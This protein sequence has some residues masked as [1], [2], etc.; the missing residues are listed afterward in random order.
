MPMYKQWVLSKDAPILNSKPKTSQKLCE[1]DFEL[2]EEQLR[3]LCKGEI[4]CRALFL[5]ID[6]ITRLYISYG[7]GPGGPMPGR[8]VARIVESKNKNFPKGKLVVGSMGWQTYSIVHPETVQEMAGQT[9]RLVEPLPN[10]L[11]KTMTSGN[12]LPKSASLGVLGIPGLTAHLALIKVANAQPGETL[13]ISSAAGQIGHLAGQIGKALGLHVIGY[14]GDADKASWIKIELGLDW[15]F[16]YKTQDVHQTLKIAAPKGVDIFLDSVGGAMHQTVLNHMNFN[17]RVVQLGNLAMYDAPG[18]IEMVP[19][20]DLVVG[21][22]SLTITG[23]NVYKYANDFYDSL[24]ELSSMC[25][26]GKIQPHE[27]VVEGFENMPKALI[28]Q[29]DGKSQGK[30]I[31]RV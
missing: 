19:A 18:D 9:V 17:G 2:V 13:V 29:L 24:D 30:T 12:Q 23:F 7:L 5:S 27:N 4:L 3:E 31:L 14:T 22:K 21:L 10:Q 20:N 8:Q 11:N 1:K 6:P 15:A 25:T 28:D 26:N 16:N